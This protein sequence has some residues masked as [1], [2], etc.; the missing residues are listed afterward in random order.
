MKEKRVDKDERDQQREQQ[1]RQRFE[2]KFKHLQQSSGVVELPKSLN[3]FERAMAHEVATSLGL[4]H[5][6]RG[7]VGMCRTIFCCGKMLQC[8]LY[9]LSKDH[10]A[11]MTMRLRT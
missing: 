8:V 4:Q 5:E 6:S 10:H 1:L 9:R 3:P 2:Q 7:P 11:C